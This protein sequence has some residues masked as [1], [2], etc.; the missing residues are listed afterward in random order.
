[1][2]A[3]AVFSLL[4]AGSAAA[5][6]EAAPEEEIE[7]DAVAVDPAAQFGEARGVRSSAN[8]EGVASQQRVDALSDETET[9]F[10]RYSNALRQVDSIR[11]Y[12]RQMRQLIGSQE[13]ELASLQSQLDRIEIVGRSVTP[14]MLRMIDAID[15]FVELD[16]PFLIDER[17][18][19]V[20]ELRKMMG[21]ADVTNAEKFRQIMEAYQVENEY[22]RT[23]EAYRGT[24]E[25]DGKALTVDFLR[26]GRIALVYQT[27]DESEAGVWNQKD[28]S[29]DPLDSGYRSAIR[30][31][32]RIARK[33]AAP[34]L[35]RLPLP[36][37]K[38]SGGAS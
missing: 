27:L 4:L 18:E 16:V 15:S 31:G 5:L 2:G 7:V 14:L 3:V 26:F 36:A 28:R 19:R 21:R 8:E 35:I 37:A 38:D 32:L 22:G 20:A 24:L 25:R 34:D 6:E 11:I 33:Q 30:Q 1:M 29:W 13:A 9:L 23:L 12:N 10:S 17:E